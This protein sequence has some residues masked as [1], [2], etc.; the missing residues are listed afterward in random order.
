MYAWRGLNRSA[1]AGILDTMGMRKAAR[2]GVSAPQV[3]GAAGPETARTD[4][5]ARIDGSVAPAAFAEAAAPGETMP[6]ARQ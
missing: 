1:L 4:P 5:S 2:P 3:G 6:R